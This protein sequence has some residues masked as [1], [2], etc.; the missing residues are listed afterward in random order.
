MTHAVKT[1]TPSLL[2]NLL[3]TSVDDV[4]STLEYCTVDDL[5]VL[6]EALHL[7]QELNYKTKAIMIVRKIN[8][9]SPPMKPITPIKTK[10]DAAFDAGHEVFWQRSHSQDVVLME[11]T[12]T[13]ENGK[14]R[15]RKIWKF[16][17]KADM[18]IILAVHHLYGSKIFGLKECLEAAWYD[19]VIAET[20][21]QLL[22]GA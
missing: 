10:V 7:A 18:Q 21:N 14:F 19:G 13:Y 16:D 3:F 1:Y 17:M 5:D 8:K 22:G 11:I 12:Y 2:N 15:Q 20:A 9:L 4:R 6:R